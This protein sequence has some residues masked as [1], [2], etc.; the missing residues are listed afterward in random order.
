MRLFPS[1]PPVSSNSV[2]ETI[3]LFSAGKRAADYTSSNLT[4]HYIRNQIIDITYR[5][6]NSETAFTANGSIFWR[7]IGDGKPTLVL[8]GW[9]SHS[10]LMLPVASGLKDI[11]T[12]FLPDLP[13]FGQSPPPE[14]P[15]CVDDYADAV[16]QFVDEVLPDGPFDLLVHSF[17]ARIALK[18]L[19]NKEFASRIEKVVFTGAAGLKPRRKPDYYF[20]KY[21]AL[22][23]KAPFQLL[24][25]TLRE[26]GLDKLRQSSI[27]KRLGSSDYQTLSGVMRETFVKTVSEF[28]DP[29]L[30]AIEHE[31]LL[32]WGENDQATPPDQGKR[33]E[34][35]LKNGTLIT[36]K[37]A[38]HYAFLD[39]PSLFNSI[40]WAYLKPPK[41]RD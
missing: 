13:G 18:L 16:I 36:M 38:G 28:L 6:L 14:N 9:G 1:P 15:W 29:L 33:M 4:V 25:G 21:T 5:L 19:N 39:Q 24:P 35:G 17:G 27:W 40:V 32:I 20:R 7:K 11:R 34:A 22:L 37:E 2:D 41:I 23:L 3:Q 12:F 8:H 31:I 30:P 26:R 10:Q